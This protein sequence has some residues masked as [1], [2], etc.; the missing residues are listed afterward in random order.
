MGI[1]SR[2]MIDGAY[3]EALLKLKT[4]PLIIPRLKTHAEKQAGL[5]EYYKNVRTN[6]LLVWCLSNVSDHPLCA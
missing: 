2:L 6:V 4:R 5:D 3:D 1:D